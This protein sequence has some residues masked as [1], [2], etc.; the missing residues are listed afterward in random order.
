MPFFASIPSTLSRTHADTCLLIASN[1][2]MQESKHNRPEGRNARESRTFLQTATTTTTL[3]TSRVGRSGGNILDTA[4]SHARASK[5]TEGG[6]SAGTGGLGAVTC[7]WIH[8]SIYFFSRNFVQVNI[9]IPPVAR[10][11]MCKA[12]IPS[13][14]QRAA[15]SWAANMA[16]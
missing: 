11:L 2:A 4:D 6:L 15:T 10:I 12:L 16:A 14:L 5:G 1:P 7:W 9:N 3:A 13:S 8:L